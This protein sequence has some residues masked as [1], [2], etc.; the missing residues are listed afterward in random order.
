MLPGLAGH[1]ARGAAA[2]L[3][4]V[5]VTI[6]AAGSAAAQTVTLPVPVATIYP[7]DQITAGMLGEKAFRASTVSGGFID[8]R[9]LLI[10]KVARR[11]LLPGHAVAFNAID[12]MDIVTRGTPVQ[13]I[14]RQEGLVITAFASPLQDGSAGDIIRLR[15]ADSGTVVT[16]VVQPDGTVSVNR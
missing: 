3:L 15:N 2:A 6:G 9:N 7:G 8:S 16:G 13:L 14:F 10:G 1:L 5:L 12:E 11:T 4:A